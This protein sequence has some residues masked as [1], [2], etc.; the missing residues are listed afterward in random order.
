MDILQFSDK[1]EDQPA[2]LQE[3]KGNRNID[4]TKH[5]YKNKYSL[6]TNNDNEG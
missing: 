5:N 6:F 1:F 2:F 4:G 3:R